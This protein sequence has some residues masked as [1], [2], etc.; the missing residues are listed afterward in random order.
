VPTFSD[1]LMHIM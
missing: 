1:A